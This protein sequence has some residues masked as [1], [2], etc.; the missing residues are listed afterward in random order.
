MRVS[1]AVRISYKERGKNL[2]GVS[3]KSNHVLRIWRQKLSL[4]SIPMAYFLFY[5][6]N[7]PQGSAWETTACSHFLKWRA[8]VYI[9]RKDRV[10]WQRPK[11]PMDKKAALRWWQGVKQR[12][13]RV[14]DDSE[15][16]GQGICLKL[17]FE[18]KQSMHRQLPWWRWPQ[19]LEITALAKY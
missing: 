15:M 8:Y 19:C 18:I 16:Y 13:T 4:K 5:C 10:A 14:A 9:L 6:K 11:Q 1:L 7:R 2:V 17:R 12:G 3:N